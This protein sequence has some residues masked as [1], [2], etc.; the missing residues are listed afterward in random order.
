MTDN[1]QPFRVA[2]GDDGQVCVLMQNV[3]DIDQPTIDLAG[4]GGFAKPGPIAAAMSRMLTG[5][6]KTR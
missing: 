3:R 2:L 1:V 4:Q 6:S 5:G